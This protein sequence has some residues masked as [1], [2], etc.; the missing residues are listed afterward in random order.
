[1]RG[2]ARGAGRWLILAVLVEVV[3]AGTLATAFTPF[4]APRAL[5]LAAEAIRP[6]AWIC[7]LLSL[8]QGA[9]RGTALLGGMLVATAI[10]LLQFATAFVGADPQQRF[11]AGLLAAVLVLLCVEQ[12]YRNTAEHDR[13]AVKFLC[14]ALAA[15]AVFDLVLYAD[16]LL[17][18]RFELGWWIARGYAH[19]LMVPL[20]AV[21]AARSPDW[22][23]DF[24]VS[25]KVVFHTATLLISGVFLLA[26]SA[27]G[28]GLRFFG[29]AWGG[30]AQTLVVFG[31]LVGLVALVASGQ[32]RARLRVL[33]S[34]HFFSY[35]YDY[36]SEWLR[37][38]D[39]LAQSPQSGSA[40]DS[41][42]KRALQG[43][44]SL[45]ESPGGALWL[46]GD[47]GRW[48][49][50]AR[51]GATEREPIADGDPMLAFLTGRDWILDVDEWKRH[52]GRYD[53]IALPGW[54]RSDPQSW[55]VV[56]LMLHQQ[57]I[58]LVMLQRPVVPLTLDWEVRDVLKTAGR[59]IAGYLA[60]REAVEKLVQARQF[61]SFNRMSAF[62]VHDLKNLV[63]QLSLLLRNAAR[64]RDNPE[65]QRDMLETVE[66]VLDRMQGLLLQLRVGTRPI[67]QPAPTRLGSTVRAAVTAKTGL[68]L[69][70]TV[71][72][73]ADA[74]RCEIIAHPDRLERVVGH[75]LQNAV[76]ATPAGGTV[77]VV[78]RRDGDQAVVEVIDTGRGMSREFVETSLFRPFTSTKEHG[79][80]IGAFES[81]EYVREIGGS[82]TVTS[83]EG[84]GTTFSMRLPVHAAHAG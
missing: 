24:R 70:P 39:L 80:G 13:W 68:R 53:H 66:N 58:G 33:L 3:W 7:F 61:E 37:L 1:V 47:D 22:Q 54:L 40:S 62:V 64:H 69:E 28:Y 14:L 48:T 73:D 44:A 52:P 12:V 8:M 79:M 21:T 42:S 45:V 75:L 29:G 55:L 38:T 77:R 20:I 51:S 18:G 49:C 5:V 11:S 19:A 60:V 27:I 43:M 81:R 57:A 71:D 15:L 72:I 84:R 56:P 78:A 32:L 82:L 10:G 4:V 74:D 63:A 26:V 35:R 59:Q 36:R 23:F 50:D 30:V 83:V 2:R 6:V 31:A 41:L 16:A 46:R 25:R 76:E 65:F 9:T 34:K 17:F 67:E